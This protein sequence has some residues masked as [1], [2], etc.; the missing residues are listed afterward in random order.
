MKLSYSP[1]TG[2]IVMFGLATF[3]HPA[4]RLAA[5]PSGMP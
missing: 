3:P 4:R 1:Y 5:G 2:S